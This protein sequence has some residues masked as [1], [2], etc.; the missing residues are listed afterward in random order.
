MSDF[1]LPFDD[2]EKVIKARDAF[3]HIII[4]GNRATGIDTYISNF[5]YNTSIDISG[6]KYKDDWMFS[7]ADQCIIPVDSILPHKYLE[8]IL[9]NQH[10]HENKDLRP[11][12]TEKIT[13]GVLKSLKQ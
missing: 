4:Y 6:I 13:N 9:M 1:L 3:E 5:R 11:L 8:K 2:Y 10:R 12:L 7:W